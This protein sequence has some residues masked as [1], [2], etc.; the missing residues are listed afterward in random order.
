MEIDREGDLCASN[1]LVEALG[2]YRE[3]SGNNGA[4]LMTRGI[5]NVF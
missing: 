4:L 5:S 2:K 1:F 3:G